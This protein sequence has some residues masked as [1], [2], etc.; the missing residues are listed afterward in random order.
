MVS[1]LQVVSTLTLETVVYVIYTT[2]I[3]HTSLSSKGYI[4]THISYHTHSCDVLHFTTPLA[5][6][7]FY[8]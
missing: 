2:I 4:L 5:F 6:V 3:S 8:S 7:L 1:D